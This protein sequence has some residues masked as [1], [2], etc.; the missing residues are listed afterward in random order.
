M[1]VINPSDFKKWLHAY[2]LNIYYLLEIRQKEK[3]VLGY[4]VGLQSLNASMTNVVATFATVVTFLVHVYTGNDLTASQVCLL[5]EIILKRWTKWSLNQLVIKFMTGFG[6][7]TLYNF[8]LQMQL[9]HA[10]VVSF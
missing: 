2:V 7:L 1:C 9:S 4:S 3:S 8:C 6:P 10:I 5:L